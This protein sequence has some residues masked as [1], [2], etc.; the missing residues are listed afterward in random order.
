MPA[1]RRA[2]CLVAFSGGRDSSLLLAA[3]VA[4]AKRVGAPAPVA[5]T[6]VYPDVPEADESRWQERVVRHLGVGD[7]LRLEI[8]DELDL[9]GPLATAGLERHG[10]R[11]PANGHSLNPLMEAAAG[12]TLVTGLGGDELLTGNRWTPLNYALARR[13]RPQV[14]DVQA[15]GLACVPRPLRVR[16]QR[17]RGPAP[18]GLGW[19]TD[20]ANRRR[21]RLLTPL[22]GEPVRWSRA[23]HEAASTRAVRLAM[24]TIRLHG[25][26]LGVDVRAPLIEP[27]VVAALC[28]AGGARGW[29]GR[30]AAMRAIAG[31][32][33][34]EAVSSRK[35]KAF[36]NSVF[37]GERVRAFAASWSGEGVD[38]TLVNAQA[39]RSEWL[40]ECPDIRSALLL[41]AAWLH[42]HAGLVARPVA[43]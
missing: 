1:L 37:F 13:R 5:A 14:A 12:G 38:A 32:R 42:D 10:L 6:L 23:V 4:A 24:E 34:P 11:F 36:F 3:A 29:G 28:R 21:R 16:I 7:W 27:A 33:L 26:E 40:S 20:E 43:A 39:L 31:D 17:S 30:S 41:Q 35:D 15:L 22:A 18:P 25:R 9:V 8:R 2:P 19:L